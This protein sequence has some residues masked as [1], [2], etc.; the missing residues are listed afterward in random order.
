MGAV[1]AVA[2]MAG[3][4]VAYAVTNPLSYSAKLTYKGKPT[5]KKPVNLAYT[6]TLHIDTDPAGTQPDTAPITSVYFAKPIKNNAA[7]FPFCNQTE[8]DGQ[9]T[10][11]SK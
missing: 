3:T 5:T 9:G 8:I 7:Y 2:V 11:P 6:G 4:G 10:F 1:A